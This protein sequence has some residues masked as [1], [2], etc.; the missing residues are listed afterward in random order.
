MATR[1]FSSL[2][3]GGAVSSTMSAGANAIKPNTVLTNGASPLP[4][5]GSF[6][7]QLRSLITGRYVSGTAAL[8]AGA[9]GHGPNIGGGGMGAAASS[10]SKPAKSMIVK[11]LKDMWLEEGTRAFT[12]GLP[13]TLLCQS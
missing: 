6:F 8:H 12:R 13:C 3:K 4:D 11:T 5:H 9:D 7:H 10:S 2:A 1:E